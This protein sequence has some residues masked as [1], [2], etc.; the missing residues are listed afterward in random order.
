MLGAQRIN[1]LDDPSAWALA[2]RDRIGDATRAVLEEHP[3]TSCAR[4]VRLTAQ[5]ETPAFGA[6]NRFTLPADFVQLIELAPGGTL[7]GSVPYRV[8]EGAIVCDQTTIGLVYVSDATPVARWS[9]LLREAVAARLAMAIGP[10]LGKP[11]TAGAARI[12]TDALKRARH[13]SGQRSLHKRGPQEDWTRV[14]TGGDD[15]GVRGTDVASP[16]GEWGGLGANGLGG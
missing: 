11:D 13:A 14:R 4:R 5:T 15:A 12:Y 8:E 3:W 10:I 7:H 2:C 16:L 9:P 6:G 1:S